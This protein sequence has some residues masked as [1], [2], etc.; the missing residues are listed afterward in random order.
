M[1]EESKRVKVM[2]LSFEFLE[3]CLRE[4]FAFPNDASI[5]DAT[6]VHDIFQVPSR[7]EIL[8]KI[9]DPQFPIVKENEQVQ[10]VKAVVKRELGEAAKFEWD[11]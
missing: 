3:M 5:M 2:S 11:K 6:V 1:N 8:L 9:H 10:C 7:R 4:A